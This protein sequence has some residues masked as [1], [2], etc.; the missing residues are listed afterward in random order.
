M[1]D[2]HIHYQLLD[3]IHLMGVRQDKSHRRVDLGSR[4]GLGG[5]VDL[6]RP[7]VVGNPGCFITRQC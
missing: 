5:E 6:G 4:I 7:S 3:V 2:L 1:E